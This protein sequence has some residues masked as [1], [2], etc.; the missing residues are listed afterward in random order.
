M[1]DQRKYFSE[2]TI[3]E[4]RSGLI[5]DDK[6]RRLHSCKEK[7]RTIAHEARLRLAVRPYLHEIRLLPEID[8][9]LLSGLKSAHEHYLRVQQLALTGAECSLKALDS[10]LQELSADLT[11]KA[12]VLQAIRSF[13]DKFGSIP[14]VH[15]DMPRPDQLDEGV[16]H[17][18]RQVRAELENTRALLIRS[19]SDLLANI[20]YSRAHAFLE[21][22][23]SGKSV[24]EAAD[25][26]R[27]ARDMLADVRQRADSTQVA[28]G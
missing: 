24:A 17:F 18:E 3:E 23:G 14:V 9:K 12:G 26:F 4:Q 20:I 13:N 25:V 2:F 19:R 16:Y 8:P 11:K 6:L 5:L 27:A 22:G 28:A 1:S 21:D 10:E 15:E 7:Q